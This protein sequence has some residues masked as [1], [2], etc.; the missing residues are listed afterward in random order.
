MARSW[1]GPKRKQTLFGAK[2]GRIV[3]TDRRLLFLSTGTNDLGPG[4]F[5]AG[6]VSSIAVLSTSATDGL[7]LSAAATEGGLDL[8]RDRI[9]KSELKGMFKVLTVTWVGHD[10]KEEAATFAPKNGGMPDGP[11]WVAEI[12]Q[13]RWS[14]VQRR[15]WFA[16]RHNPRDCAMAGD[17]GNRWLGSYVRYFADGCRA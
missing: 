2:L 12:G 9:R 10:G 7:D 8:R 6:A 15:S 3:L 5:A 11:T 14:L 17:G 1:D 13:G 16:P 4:R